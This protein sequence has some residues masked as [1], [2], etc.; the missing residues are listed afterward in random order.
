MLSR[1]NLGSLQCCDHRTPVGNQGNIRAV[2]FDIS[3]AEWDQVFFLGNL[4]SLAVE[5][6]VL[7]ETHGIVVPDRCLHQ[8]LGVIGCG[9]TH[10]FEA[11]CV[12]N[13][14][15]RRV[16]V[17]CTHISSPVC[18][19]ADD[20][21][22][23]DESTAHVADLASVVDDLVPCHIGEAPKHELHHG[24]NTQHRSPYAHADKTGLADWG[25]HHTLVAEALP[26]SLSDFVGAVVLGHF[27]S[28]NDDI[29]IADNF[30][31][32]RVV[33]GFAVGDQ[34]HSVDLSKF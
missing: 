10:D 5:K 23:I 14:I 34:R 15:F 25:I 8:S 31:G 20:N 22:A 7:H 24:A 29:L 21:R 18:R 1:E 2:A 6:S 16:R 11:R 13:E 12:G 19:A 30:L 26:K 28:D 17:G 27:F 3:H 9:W 32:E 4:P 33:E